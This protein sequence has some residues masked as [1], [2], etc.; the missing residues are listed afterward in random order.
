MSFDSSVFTNNCA[1]SERARINSDVLIA[2]PN[3][4]SAKALVGQTGGLTGD[5]SPDVSTCPT[6]TTT[7]G[8]C[9]AGT[10]TPYHHVTPPYTYTAACKSRYTASGS[11]SI[12][13]TLI[14]NTYL[15]CLDACDVSCAFRLQLSLLTS[16]RKTTIVLT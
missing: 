7:T 10:L 1:M 12:T 16:P 14:V 8:I 11:G 9:S 3:I 4:D 15:Q 6:C 13:S 2:N 5:F